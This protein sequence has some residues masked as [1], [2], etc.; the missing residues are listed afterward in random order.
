MFTKRGESQEI[1]NQ[2]TYIVGQFGEGGEI[3]DHQI[4]LV[5]PSQQAVNRAKV[6]LKE[7][8]IGGCP[9]RFF[10]PKTTINTKRERNKKK[11]LIYLN[12]I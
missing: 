5:T 3:S 8:K 4:E 11:L 6:D 12:K 10:L 1:P 7:K 9:V 2:K